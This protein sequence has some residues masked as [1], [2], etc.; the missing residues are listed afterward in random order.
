MLIFKRPM[1]INGTD[2]KIGETLPDNALSKRQIKMYISKEWLGVE[3][4]PS[5]LMITSVE[6]LKPFPVVITI[7]KDNENI[8]IEL[9][10]TEVDFVFDLLQTPV[11]DLAD[12]VELIINPDVLA[13]AC[14][15]DNRKTATALYLAKA[16]QMGLVVDNAN[17][18][19]QEQEG[20]SEEQGQ[21]DA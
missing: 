15:S 1:R 5:N 16:K 17:S 18:D 10:H 13:V 20:E 14:A 2:Y 7:R 3:T 4:E 12:K 11:K 6:E 9:S 19:E 21:G 8:S